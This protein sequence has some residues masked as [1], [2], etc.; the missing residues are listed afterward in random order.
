MFFAALSTANLEIDATVHGSRAAGLR[1]AQ[2]RRRLHALVVLVQGTHLIDEQLLLQQLAEQRCE[3]L[4]CGAI[5]STLP[6]SGLQMQI[7][8]KPGRRAYQRS[9]MTWKVAV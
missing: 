9:G 7:P 1:D 4:P 5:S 2:E 3:H 6:G 8:G